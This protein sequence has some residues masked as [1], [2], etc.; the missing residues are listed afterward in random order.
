VL[1]V[2][3]S[4]HVI[5]LDVDSSGYDASRRIRG[6]FKSGETRRLE[7]TVDGLIKRDLTLVWGS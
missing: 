6:V 1:N 5:R 3:P 4:E 7:A 2:P